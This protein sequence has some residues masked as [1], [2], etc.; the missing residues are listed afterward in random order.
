M[1]FATAL[2]LI[3]LAGALFG[4]LLAIFPLTVD[5]SVMVDRM[6]QSGFELTPL[7]RDLYQN[8]RGQLSFLLFSFFVI[9]SSVVLILGGVLLR[10]QLRWDAA[11][12]EP[13]LAERRA[14]EA[15]LEDYLTQ[16]TNLLLAQGLRSSSELRRLVLSGVRSFATPQAGFHGARL[17]RFL[18]ELNLDWFED[19]GSEAVSSWPETPRM[20]N[21]FPRLMALGLLVILGFLLIWSILIILAL[22]VGKQVADLGLIVLALF[23]GKPLADSGLMMTPSEVL[24]TVLF[25]LTLAAMVALA[26]TSV[27]L[28]Q[29]HE[30]RLEH[31][32]EEALAELRAEGVEAFRQRL[33]RLIEAKGVGGPQR[34]DLV[35]QIAKALALSVLPE[36]D[37][38]SQREILRSLQESGLLNDAD[39]IDW[40]D[41][42]LDPES[43]RPD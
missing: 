27:V 31:R 19:S 42:G 22:T 7:Q 41:T 28:L 38:D 34:Q 6:V 10:F 16:L 5:G 20:S 11:S 25:V 15:A 17:I 12:V 40:P 8:R 37:T 13:D 26:G 43:D 3:G 39:Q 32:R 18:R 14:R 1:L 4:S 29:K 23:I 35:S 30:E 24:L 21:F 9:P 33:G 2:L 36:H